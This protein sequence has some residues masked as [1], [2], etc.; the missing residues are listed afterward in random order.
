MLSKKTTDMLNQQINMEL[1]SAYL[2]LG[3]SNYL[4]SIGHL[5]YAH[6]YRVQAQE[7]RD[8]AMLIYDYLHMNNADVELEKL[9]KPA[10]K[11]DGLMDVLKEGLKHEE[12]I[13]ASI[14]NI[15]AAALEEKDY[16]T[17]QFLD[18]FVKEQG[19]EEANAH[20]L[21]Q[22]T[23]TFGTDAKGLYMLNSELG[24]RVYAP[25]SLVL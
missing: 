11:A 12:Y 5:G 7:E 22:K 18:W 1:F 16:R 17:V 10:F 13:T 14:H 6:W 25:P 4:N 8:H 23:E 3:F 9:D 24:A 15:Y 20:E 19:E 2:Y 21:I